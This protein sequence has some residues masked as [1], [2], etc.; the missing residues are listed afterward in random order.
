MKAHLKAFENTDFLLITEHY[1]LTGHSA[2]SWAEKILKV[3][4]YQ[5]NLQT[6]MKIEN[7]SS[8]E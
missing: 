1:N 2:K 8:S 7:M 5:S 3:V 4:L 6:A